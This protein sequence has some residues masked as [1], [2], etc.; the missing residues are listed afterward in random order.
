MDATQ[1]TAEQIQSLW[2]RHNRQLAAVKRWRERKQQEDPEYFHKYWKRYAAEHPD[3][4]RDK[5]ARAAERR[6]ARIQVAA[7]GGQPA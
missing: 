3:K 6:Q 2:Q 4:I 1:L 5:N 7:A